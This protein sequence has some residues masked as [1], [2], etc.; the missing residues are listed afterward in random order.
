[1][2]GVEEDRVR[3]LW[4]VMARGWAAGD[5]EAF[6]AVFAEDCD[7]TTVRGEK[8]GG[9]AGVAARH[10]QL[11][12]T[13]FRGTTLRSRID[14]VRPLRSG[15]ATVDVAAEVLAADGQRLLA[16]HALAVVARDAAGAWRIV[17]F[18][19]MVPVG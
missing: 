16:T 12:R 18:H 9:R 10:D 5:A 14:A 3:E 7:F 4:A 11:F 15:L 17:A 13:A 6:A 2:S 1:M 8:P 19:N